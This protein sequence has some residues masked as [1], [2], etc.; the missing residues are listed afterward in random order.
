MLTN[1][2]QQTQV[3]D[4]IKVTYLELQDAGVMIH[5]SHSN[6]F[7]ISKYFPE[8]GV[9]SEHLLDL[10]SFYDIPVYCTGHAWTSK[11]RHHL[12][13]SVNESTNVVTM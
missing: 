11:H 6:Q 7:V 13:P 4:F 1:Y 3:W 2:Q 9:L 8:F 12:Y 10:A 5:T